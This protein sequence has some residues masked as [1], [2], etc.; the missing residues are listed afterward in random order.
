MPESKFDTNHLVIHRN[1]ALKTLNDQY[2]GLVAQESAR[3]AALVVT[4]DGSYAVA[5]EDGKR[6]SKL[7]KDIEARRKELKQPFLDGGKAVD[8][9][10]K[11]LTEKIDPALKQ[12]K[13]SM[14]KFADD[15]RKVIEEEKR[16]LEAEQR[17]RE[18]EIEA[19]KQKEIADA[20]AAEQANK[21]VNDFFK[22]AGLAQPAASVQAEVV[23]GQAEIEKQQSVLD[24][25]AAQKKLDQ[26][27]PKGLRTRW[28]FE[29]T[30][31]S[32][33]PR[34]FLSINSVAINAAIRDGA[35]EIAGVRIYQ[36]QSVA[37]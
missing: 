37:L 1:H 20:K 14:T 23:S 32:Q 17:K 21:G 24:F 19:K 7:Q 34:E 10:A 8:D 22:T 36:E 12:L 13:T 16:K 29:V 15:K 31:E 26:D 35:R 3:V 4:D 27:K 33:V 28:V 5:M 9:L 25:Q 11:S 18:Q 6:L 2:Q 30:D